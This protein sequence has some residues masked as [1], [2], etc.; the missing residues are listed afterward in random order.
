ME[1][2][3]KVR[4]NVLKDIEQNQKEDFS[5]VVNEKVE[6]YRAELTANYETERLAKLNGL[7]VT[8]SYLDEAIK[9]VEEAQLSI[10][11]THII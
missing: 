5:I 2:L 9:E 11:I 7:N 1:S 8:L 10:P 4:A 6:K 3:K